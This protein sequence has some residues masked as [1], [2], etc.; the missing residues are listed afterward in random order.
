V[1][2]WD[3]GAGE[4]SVLTIAL[5]DPQ[6]EAI[7]DDRDARRC[8]QALRIAVRGTFGLV[9]LAK[10]IGSLPLARPVVEQLRR[11]GLF[12]SDQLADQALALVGE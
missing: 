12:L 9:I 7:L 10:Q 1:L 2:V 8:A 4:S 5:T 3:L 11:S 6:C